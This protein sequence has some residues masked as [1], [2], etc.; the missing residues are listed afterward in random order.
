LCDRRE[1]GPA[2]VV[3]RFAAMDIAALDDPAFASVFM[4]DFV[5]AVAAAAGVPT[6]SIRVTAVAAG[7]VVVTFEVVLPSVT[8][9]QAFVRL[10]ETPQVRG[11]RPE[12]CFPGASA[13]PPQFPGVSLRSRI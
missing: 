10:A 2:G 5:T 11:V 13:I 8:A 4:N 7:S 12:G 1:R 3:F 9:A 6:A